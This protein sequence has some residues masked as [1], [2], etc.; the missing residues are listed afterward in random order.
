M[1]LVIDGLLLLFLIYLTAKTKN[2]ANQQNDSI[3]MFISTLILNIF[4]Y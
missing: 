1:E 2:A 3:G 4:F